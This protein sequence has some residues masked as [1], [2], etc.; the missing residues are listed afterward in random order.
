[1]PYRAALECLA[2]RRYNVIYVVLKNKECCREIP[3]GQPDAVS[4]PPRN[5]PHQQLLLMDHIAVHKT[6][7]E[8]FTQKS[9]QKIDKTQGPL[10]QTG[11][12]CREQR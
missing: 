11:E 8:N 9:Q 12:C 6:H 4:P 5:Q 7:P 1:M 3:I 2:R 10:L